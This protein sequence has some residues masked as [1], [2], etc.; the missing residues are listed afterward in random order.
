MSAPVYLNMPGDNYGGQITNYAPDRTGAVY[1]LNLCRLT[2]NGP[3]GPRVYRIPPKGAPQ[4]IAFVQDASAGHLVVANRKLYFLYSVNGKC[5]SDQIDGY[6]D[7]DN[8][9]S[10][11]VVDI[12]TSQIQTLQQQITTTNQQLN[13]QNAKI[14]QLQT[15]VNQQSKTLQT[16][17]AQISQVQS[18]L[19][20]QSQVE[21]I[22]WTK[23]WDI[24]YLIRLGYLQGS[25]TIQNVQAWLNDLAVYIRSIAK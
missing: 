20:T 17:Q 14:A 6:I 21:D 4:L 5:Y 16:M 1:S 3:W 12:N 11:N 2:P 10:S 15:Q 19:L 23:T 13:A 22:V 7:P 24:L 9:P 8:T 25:S 18:Q